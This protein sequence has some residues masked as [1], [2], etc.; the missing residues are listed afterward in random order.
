MINY[1]RL[2]KIYRALA[3]S[4]DSLVRIYTYHQQIKALKRLEGD[5]MS[6]LGRKTTKL[7]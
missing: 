3:H 7:K 1:R 6:G 2:F 4:F 5:I